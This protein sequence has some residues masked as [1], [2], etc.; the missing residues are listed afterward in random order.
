MGAALHVHVQQASGAW[1][2]REWGARIKWPSME[3]RAQ[4][5][6]TLL[7]SDFGKLVVSLILAVM[8]YGHIV[9]LFIV[10]DHQ[11]SSLAVT[12]PPPKAHATV[13]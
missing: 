13:H 6:F 7:R 3:E 11:S 2:G 9:L 4:H 12:R 8:V 10:N 1:N 5:I